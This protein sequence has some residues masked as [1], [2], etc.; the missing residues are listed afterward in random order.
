MLKKGTIGIL[1]GLISGMFGAGGGL[2]L[3]SIFLHVLKLEEKEARA[4][5]IASILPMAITT[6]IFYFNNNLIDWNL[7]IKCAVGGIVGV[8]IG[9]KLLR[10]LSNTVLR[11]IFIVF[12][13]YVAYK[14]II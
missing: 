2:V 10:V 7:A 1:A 11:V 12:L 5:T 14:L 8:V 6:G 3:L 9:T 4:T 13:V